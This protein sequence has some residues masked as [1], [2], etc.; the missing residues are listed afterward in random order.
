MRLIERKTS[1][2]LAGSF[3]CGIACGWTAGHCQ[4]ATVNVQLGCSLL[5]ALLHCAEIFR[6]LTWSVADIISAVEFDHTGDYLATGDKGGRVVLFE[7][8]ESV[9]RLRNIKASA[10][11]SNII[12]RKKD[13]NTSSTPSFSRTN[14][15]SII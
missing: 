6:R 14:Q 11:S 5:P 4:Q 10:T 12:F 7:R 1:A 13:A 9:R 2:L 8:N 3:T 15:N